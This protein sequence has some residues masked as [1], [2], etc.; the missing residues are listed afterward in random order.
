LRSRLDQRAHR[1]T[2][3]GRRVGAR[4]VAAVGLA[5]LVATACGSS[6]PPKV[7]TM[8][9]APVMRAIAQTIKRQHRI[10]TVVVCPAHPKKKAGFRFTC[11][12]KLAVGSYPVEVVETNS[13]GGVR[14]SNSTPLRLLNSHTVELAI[15]RAV[16][17]QRRLKAT[18]VCPAPILQKAGLVF[19][20][21]VR[22]K[23]GSSRFRVTEANSRGRVTFVGL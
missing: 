2:A 1:S 8:A 15:Q 18:V 17:A 20:C 21:T 23:R 16:H 3:P 19:T 4:A 9:T 11:L 6:S 13:H 10:S 12:A 5:A 22:T 7:A 14:F